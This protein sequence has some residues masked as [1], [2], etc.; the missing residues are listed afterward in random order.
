MELASKQG[1]FGVHAVASQVAASQVAREFC[2]GE[3]GSAVQGALIVEDHEVA[4][5]QA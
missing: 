4:V 2:R 3:G 5:A 1:G